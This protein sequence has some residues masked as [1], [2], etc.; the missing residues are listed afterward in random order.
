[1]AQNISTGI[2]INTYKMMLPVVTVSAEII[3]NLK[4]SQLYWSTR[5][6]AL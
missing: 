4:L 5:F 3:F 6:L 2:N 1:M